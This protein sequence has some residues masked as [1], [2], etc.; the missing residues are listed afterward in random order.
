MQRLQAHVS[1]LL[2]AYASFPSLF[3][4]AVINALPESERNLL[5]AAIDGDFEQTSET[6]ILRIVSLHAHR[7][8][9]ALLTWP[10]DVQSSIK[11]AVEGCARE[12]ELL[13]KVE[14]VGA[15]AATDCG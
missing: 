7:A 15:S 10:T 13:V 3:E 6:P 12:I 4:E 2:D 9:E 11:S 1:G 8:R 5:L 14:R